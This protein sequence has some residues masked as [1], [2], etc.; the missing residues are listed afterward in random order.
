MKVRGPLL[1]AAAVAP[2]IAILL[3]VVHLASQSPTLK[4]WTA[5]R[6]RPARS[7]FDSAGTRIWPDCV[8]TLTPK[9]T[10]SSATAASGM[11]VRA[12]RTSRPSSGS[13]RRV[14][15]CCTRSRTISCTP[16]SSPTI[17]FFRTSGT[18]S[19]SARP[20]A[21]H[22]ARRAPTSTRRMPGIRRS[23]REPSSSASS[24]LASI[25]VIQIW[26]PTSGPPRT[27]HHHGR[28][29][30][31]HL[32]RR[33]PRVQRDHEEVRSVRR[34]LSWDPRVRHDRRSGQ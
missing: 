33:H 30:I 28:R 23:A 6:S 14:P 24:T 10:G 12:A 16:R 8:A 4:L 13:S 19:T 31:D 5:T 3:T 29:R 27:I 22:P 34:S 17:R 15:T 11:L 32:P 2:A 18:C 9:P 21:A 25:T 20:L 26:R 1:G 7:S